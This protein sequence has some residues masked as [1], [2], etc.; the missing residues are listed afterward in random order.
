MNT[1]ELLR[2]VA[3]NLEAGR[4]VG[5]GLLHK[6]EESRA[7][8]ISELAYMCPESY[9][10]A[11]RTRIINGVEVPAPMDKEPAAGS[12]YWC[13]APAAGNCSF[14]ASWVGDPADKMRFRRGQCYDS[15]EAA[16]ANCKARYGLE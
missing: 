15:P 2:Y 6:G 13:E 1:V 16:A 4:S 8:N 3:D 5:H 11:P 7:E 9:S 14:R 10:L 12:T